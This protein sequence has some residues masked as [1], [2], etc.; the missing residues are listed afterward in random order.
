MKRSK[1]SKRIIAILVAIVM[2][3]QYGLGVSEVSAATSYTMHDGAITG[4]SIK[5]YVDNDW[6]DI[7]SVSGAIK[8]G[9]RIQVSITYAPDKIADQFQVNDMILYTLPE[10]LKVTEAQS[11]TV[12]DGPLD[13]G[14]YE[15]TTGGEIRIKITNAKYLEDKNGI[16]KNGTI[17]F[18]GGFDGDYWNEGGTKEVKIGEYSY[19]I[20]LEEKE[21]EAIGDLIVDKTVVK[22]GN[23]EI[24]YDSNNNAYIEYLITVTAPAENTK[25]MES[26]KVE[27]TFTAG[28]HYVKNAE[29]V[30][31]SQGNISLNTGVWTIGNMNPGSVATLKF[32]AYLNGSF[33][34]VR[35]TTSTSSRQLTNRAVVKSQNK[36]YDEDSVTTTSN[37]G[38]NIDKRNSGYSYDEET[39]K[40]T[41]TYTVTVTAPR[42]NAE[43]IRNVSVY[44]A[45]GGTNNVKEYVVE[46]DT[47]SKPNGTSYVED[48]TNKTLLWTIGDMAPGA[49][50]ELE[51][52]VEID[53]DIF[54]DG[55]SGT[56]EKTLPNT[57][58]LKVNG[59]DVGS[60]SSEVYF[61]KEWITK[62]GQIDYNDD[63]IKFVIYV[64]KSDEGIPDLEGNL[65]VTD[66][67]SGEWQYDGDVTVKQ[68]WVQNGITREN[69]WTFTPNS[70]DRKSWEVEVDGG[71]Y[72]EFEYYVKSVGAKIGEA[73]ISNKAGVGIGV[74]GD[75]YY[76]ETTWQG[77]GRYYDS[78]AKEFV[79]A[80]GDIAVSITSTPAS[81]AFK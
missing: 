15:I 36:Y 45:F 13:V 73:S 52:T 28:S 29:V 11:G 53:S 60:D 47:V 65:T 42:T 37:W 74:G 38:L 18:Y 49:V 61:K 21:V 19:Y 78:L 59:K 5:A 70:A 71:Y 44:D 79:S 3:F 77:T 6:K 57:A 22:D 20:E 2:V 1:L 64:N 25:V 16:L 34:Y 30:H 17:S 69:R 26:V 66:E 67:L 39:N 51:Y 62:H 14:E 12:T 33:F 23:D 8:R 10:G 50:K 31:T 24:R 7:K 43:T 32:K 9:T 40:G 35:N 81:T 4:F 41:V 48:N 27:D 72:Y 54:N 46:Y 75:N 80:N 76:H 55:K 63:R 58:T 68:Y 56:V